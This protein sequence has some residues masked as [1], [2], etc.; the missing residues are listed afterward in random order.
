M[1]A[2][3]LTVPS[4]KRKVP[5]HAQPF[6]INGSFSFF[7]FVPPTE[8]LFFEASFFHK[9]TIVLATIF[10]PKVRRRFSLFFNYVLCNDSSVFCPYTLPNWGVH[11]CW[12][13]RKVVGLPLAKRCVSTIL[14]NPPAGVLGKHSHQNAIEN[15]AFVFVCFC[16]RKTSCEQGNSKVHMT[17]NFDCTIGGFGGESKRTLKVFSFSSPGHIDV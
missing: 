8:P 6:L 4:P 3:A 7:L 5:I 11:M 16:E 15:T 2:E 14:K 12:G 1:S 9:Y 17:D 10:A 13:G